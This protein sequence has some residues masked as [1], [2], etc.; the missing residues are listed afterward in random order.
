M[1][2]L[3]LVVSVA[4]YWCGTH[5]ESALGALIRPPYS[6]VSEFYGKK[7]KILTKMN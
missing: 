1:R 2:T 5:H 7:T 4:A 6:E 3:S